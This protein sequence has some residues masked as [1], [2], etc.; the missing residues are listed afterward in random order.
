[1]R[2]DEHDSNGY[3][4]IP[5]RWNVEIMKVPYTRCMETKYTMFG[6]DWHRWREGAMWVRDFK[7]EQELK[8]LLSIKDGDKYNLVSTTFG[9]GMK[10]KVPI[11][12]NNAYRNIDLQ[13]IPGYS[14]FDWAG[15]FE[16]ATTIHVVSSSNIYIMEMLD[17]QADEIKLYLR[18]PIESNHDNYN[19]L[20]ERHNYTFE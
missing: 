2:Q 3:R 19:Y 13:Y 5:L 12:V 11:V 18:K 15:V 17:L 14:L 6:M 4:V 7:K 1:M 10:H 8:N 16:Q 20:L 9:T